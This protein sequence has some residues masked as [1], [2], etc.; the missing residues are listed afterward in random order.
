VETSF[1]A[2][3]DILSELWLNYRKEF[4]FQDFIT[5]NDIGLPLSFMIAEGIVDNPTEAARS[6]VTEA[7]DLFLAALG[8]KD[9]GFEALNDVLR[10]VGMSEE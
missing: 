7:F 4:D 3:C 1:E 9:V 10:I 5:Y 8:I 2:K 6:F